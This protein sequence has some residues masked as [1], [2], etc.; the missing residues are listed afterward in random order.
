VWHPIFGEHQS[1]T[2]PMYNR[3]DVRVTRLFSPP[4][5]MGKPGGFGV[6]YCEAMNVLGIPN[7]LEYVYNSDYSQRYTRVSYFGRRIVVAG[8]ALTW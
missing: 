2:M 7:A 4:R 3:L 1:A 6:L 5:V 8:F